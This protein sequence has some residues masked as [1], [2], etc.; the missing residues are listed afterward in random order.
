MH[1]GSKVMQLGFGIGSMRL[2]YDGFNG[3][4]ASNWSM[5]ESDCDFFESHL[6]QLRFLLGSLYL[7]ERLPKSKHLKRVSF[8]HWDNRN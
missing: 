4:N 5:S 2:M 1:L 6:L 7:Q 8:I 3:C